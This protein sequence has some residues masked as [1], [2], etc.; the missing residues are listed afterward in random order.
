MCKGSDEPSQRSILSRI[1]DRYPKATSA[2]SLGCW[3]AAI[4]VLVLHA[5]GEAVRG[6]NAFMLTDS[7]LIG[8]GCIGVPVLVLNLLGRHMTPRTL[9]LI[10]AACFTGALIVTIFVGTGQSQ[11]QPWTAVFVLILLLA[12]GIHTLNGAYALDRRRRIADQVRAEEREKHDEDVHAAYLAG[13]IDAHAAL[14]KRSEDLEKVLDMPT[15]ELVGLSAALAEEIG[16]RHATRA[17]RTAGAQILQ[18]F[19]QG[20]KSHGLPPTG[21]EPD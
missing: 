6:A 5:N 7:W 18:L 3:L 11:M 21:S 9:E 20:G 1:V 4:T 13:L 14:Q 15:E 17:N 16:S 12:M 8:L 2:S 19:K 10:A